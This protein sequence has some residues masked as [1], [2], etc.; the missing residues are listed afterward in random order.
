MASDIMFLLEIYTIYFITFILSGQNMLPKSRWLDGIEADLRKLV[1]GNW[2]VLA[3]DDR[4]NGPVHNT[5][6]ESQ[7]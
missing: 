6:G 2:T 1:A 7:G 4:T 3:R 5:S